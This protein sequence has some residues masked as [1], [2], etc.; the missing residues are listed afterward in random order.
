MG[1]QHITVESVAGALGAEVSGVDLREPIGD[2]VYDEIH[3]AWMEH[4][5][6]FLRDQDLT[7]HHHK[8][9]ARHFGALHVHPV[10]QQLKD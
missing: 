8:R 10:L 6:L 5:V 7:Y 4:Q 3:S 1:Y 2:T 9:F